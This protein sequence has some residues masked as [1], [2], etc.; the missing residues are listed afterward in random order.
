MTLA[1]TGHGVSRGIAIGQAH[2]AERNELEIGE[3]RILANNVDAEVSRLR[4]ALRTAREQ[5]ELLS[6]RVTRS[7]GTAASEMIQTHI[8]MLTDSS[9][10][11][12]AEQRIRDE[13]CNAEWALQSQLETILAE[14][15]HMED[16]YIRSRGE[17][18]AQVI[19]MVQTELSKAGT[20]RSFD[21]IPDRLA[22]TLVVTTELTPGELA[23]LHER[24]VAGIVTEHGS[25]YSHAAILASSLGIP[26]VFGVRLAHSLLTEGET[27]ILDG[28]LGVVYAD[29]DDAFIEHYHE[30]ERS[31]SRFRK[32]LDE[33]RRK[34]ALTLDGEAILL[35]ANAEREDE[36]RL[37]AELD[38]D[39]VGLYRTE[40]LFMRGAAPDEAT[41]LQEYLVA[42][43]ALAGKPLTI[44]TLDLGADK[45]SEALDFS[46]L[47]SSMNPALGLRAIRLCLRDTDL[48][49][50]QLRAILRA[51]AAG[52]VR[53][54]V[55]M[56][57]SV[58]EV[59]MVKTLLDE[60]RAE[61]Q[62]RGQAYDPLM[63]L[64]GMIEV[65]AAALAIEDLGYHLDFLSIGTN[66]LLQY[67]LAADRVDEQ[68]AH[69][70]DPLHPGVVRLLHY[71]FA[72]CT[73]TRMPVTVC[74]ELA[75]DRRYTR[76]LLALGLRSFSMHPGRLL[77]VKQVILETHANRAAAALAHWL[78]LG[79]QRQDVSLLRLL[80][81][82]QK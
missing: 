49:K 73:E 56:L 63:Q 46:L 64:G 37:A 45:T 68:V 32:S 17:D 29:P 4:D 15:R 33:I 44:R 66:D 79:A 10:G 28:R 75:G 82:S 20:D 76:L 41:Q 53:C 40:F 39:G 24:G 80:D 58:H 9:I 47:R 36:I 67:A 30:I 12:A 3:Y 38:S 59:R 51:S 35:Q 18:V 54:L 60:A 70:Y 57:T 25:P 62:I 72:A 81:Q 65:P 43:A 42:I 50:T 26:A 77:E 22:D 21:S 52:K 55:P 71:M 5:L 61:L 8:L 14:F 6:D 7:A 16:E 78:N 34:P 48:F 11:D 1:L 23:L 69:L 31:T 74:G 27:L 2:L 19:R 13:L